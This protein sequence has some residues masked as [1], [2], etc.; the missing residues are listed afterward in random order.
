MCE[1]LTSPCSSST[2]LGR[3]Q[4]S[5]ANTFVSFAEAEKPLDALLS[6]FGPPNKTSPGYAFHH[7]MSDGVWIV[8]TKDGGDSPGSNRGD[9][10]SSGAECELEPAF[11]Q[12]MLS[13]P[14]LLVRIASGTY[15]TL[16]FPPNVHDDI[17]DQVGLDLSGGITGANLGSTDK[18]KRDPAF[19]K[20]VLLVYEH[21]CA[22]CN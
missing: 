6:E 17:V 18:P 8:R 13:D 15:W 20:E 12:A 1:H 5:E 7:L 16:I 21:R 9:L 11:A 22:M 10:R 14:D 19:R 2:P 4:T 3:L